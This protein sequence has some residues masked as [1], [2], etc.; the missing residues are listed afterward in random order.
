LKRKEV[1]KEIEGKEEKK[2]RKWRSGGIPSNERGEE[3][4]RREG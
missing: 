2:R 1:G 4:K 3:K